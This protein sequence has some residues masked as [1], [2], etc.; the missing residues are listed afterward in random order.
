MGA[1]SL[2]L[3]TWDC[4]RAGTDPMFPA[5]AGG[6]LTTEAPGKTLC[7]FP[8]PTYLLLLILWKPQV[9]AFYFGSEVL[10]LYHWKKDQSLCLTSSW[11]PPGTIN[12]TSVLFTTVKDRS[13]VPSESPCFPIDS[14]FGP[15]FVFAVCFL[16]TLCQ[17]MPRE[18]LFS[19]CIICWKRGFKKLHLAALSLLN[20]IFPW[21]ETPSEW[22][23]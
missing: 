18:C 23:L 4:P 6:F 13:P 15:C 20:K 12:S 1:Y 22:Q 5:L 21:P 7:F 8:S 17:I 11:L 3:C 14:H 16:M 10:N 2:P 9:V 19:Y